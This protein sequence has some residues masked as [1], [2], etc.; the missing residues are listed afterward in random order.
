MWLLEIFFLWLLIG[1]V[2]ALA[3]GALCSTG[4]E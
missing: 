2:V 4:D 1:F 3:F